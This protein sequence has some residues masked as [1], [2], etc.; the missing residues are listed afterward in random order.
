MNTN[1]LK[2]FRN[3]QAKRNPAKLL[4]SKAAF[5]DRWNNYVKWIKTNK[6]DLEKSFTMIMMRIAICKLAA[7]A[8][9]LA[10]MTILFLTHL[11]IFAPITTLFSK[12]TS[13]S[14]IGFILFIIVLKFVGIS[15]GLCLTILTTKE[16]MIS[17]ARLWFTELLKRKLC[18]FLRKNTASGNL[19]YFPPQLSRTFPHQP[20]CTE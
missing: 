12:W 20:A 13:S 1:T 14:L 2:N 17:D 7:A 5:R 10:V 16:M 6:E 18:F 9:T 8:V 4:K 3:F 11:H 19:T 15:I